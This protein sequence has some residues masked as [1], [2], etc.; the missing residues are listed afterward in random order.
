MTWL[1]LSPAKQFDIGDRNSLTKA[2]AEFSLD[3]RG[4]HNYLSTQTSIIHSDLT[5]EMRA[6]KSS[7]SDIRD[8]RP[9]A[10]DYK[11]SSDGKNTAYEKAYS[12]WQEKL[13][14]AQKDYE[15]DKEDIQDYYDGMQT[16]LETEATD[17][18]TYIQQRM[19]TIETQLTAL[20]AEF[21]SIKEE[22]SSD[23]QNSAPNF[24]G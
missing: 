16:D 11:I 7:L 1:T 5:K 14:E 6:I 13:A 20:N 15:S 12:E 22:I 24:G 4:I 23:A 9:S 2:D 8:R 19:S 10:D 18:E 21:D 17:E 3:L